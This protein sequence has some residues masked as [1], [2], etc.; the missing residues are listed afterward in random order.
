MK[1]ITK[2]AREIDHAATG[3]AFRRQREN[4]QLSLRDLGSQL[5]LSA[6][7]ICDLE[8]G[9]RQWNEKL[10]ARFVSALVRYGMKQKKAGAA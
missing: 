5:N 4:C 1:L 2:P 9:K 6:A 3:A 7:Y 8:N 10:F